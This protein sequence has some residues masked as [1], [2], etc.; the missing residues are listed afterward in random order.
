M[1]TLIV[2]LLTL[3]LAALP[4]LQPLSNQPAREHD[5]RQIAAVIERHEW[6]LQQNPALMAAFRRRAARDVAL[7]RTAMPEWAYVG[8]AASLIASVRNPHT[9]IWP[10]PEERLYLPLTF[11]WTVGGLVAVP[12]EGSP[13]GVR[14]GDRVL[15]LGG[16]TPP[17]LAATLGRY[18]PGSGYDV[19]STAVSFW[20]LTA[21]Y[22]LEWLHA[23]GPT[24]TVPIVLEDARGRVTRLDLP[25]VAWPDYRER[26]ELASTAFEDRFIA[27]PGVRVTAAAYGWRVAAKKYGVFWIRSFDASA[28][29]DRAV[30]RFFAAVAAGKA[31]NVVIDVQ[32][33]PGGD[34]YISQ[35]FIDRLLGRANVAR[36]VY[37]LTDWASFS[38]SVLLAENFLEDGI[39][40]VAGEPTG[41]DLMVNWEESFTEP[42][43]GIWFQSA[44]SPPIDPLGREAAAIYPSVPVPLTVWD[45]QHGVN[46]VGAWLSSLGG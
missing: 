9:L 7:A 33:D 40:Q 39:G 25:F 11:F 23:V 36:H 31:P 10:D 5:L 24:G 46:A 35:A 12:I 43:T 22:A 8:L 21:H 17:E 32:Q 42:E 30:A 45:I 29:L 3:L 26:A 27:P 44:A 16:K 19:R 14:L 41:E 20:L 1:R 4:V 6:S 13:P 2:S 18:T 28:G 15:S 34:P 38:A 37:V